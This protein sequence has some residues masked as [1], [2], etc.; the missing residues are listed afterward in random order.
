VQIHHLDEDPR[1]HAEQN[2]SVLCLECHNETMQR[3]GFG[4]K[5]DSEQIVLYRDDWYRSISRTRAAD[6]T[7]TP[8]EDEQLHDVTY[9]TSIAEIY[10]E[11]Q[12]FEALAR[13][14]QSLGNPDLRDKYVEL[15]LK[16]NPDSE[17][18]IYLRS[19]QGRVD[20]IPQEVIDERL[21]KLGQRRMRLRRARVNRKLGRS[22]EAVSDY[23]EGVLDR[24]KDKSYFTAAFYLKELG[25]SGLIHELF[26]QALDDA[27]SENDLWWQV[28]SL[29]ELGRYEEARELVLANE[30]DI[31]ASE[32]DLLFRE[33]L[34]L[35]KGDKAEWL[36]TR[37][38]LAK[39]GSL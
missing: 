1:N 34:A 5:L 3:G 30:A 4:R 16:A 24:L 22:E 38:E 17:T 19:L 10:R 23:L 33:L 12:N 7:G 14:Y 35:A 36:K 21:R 26:E 31:L 28:R 6:Y 39:T 37:M 15:A 11:Q 9:A 20:L 27:E 18:V 32:D 13:H 29:E 25:E 8:S 2:L